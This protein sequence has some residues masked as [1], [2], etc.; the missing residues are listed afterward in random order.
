MQVLLELEDAGGEESGGRW[1]EA[2]AER[3]VPT[4]VR[5]HGVVA[6][7]PQEFWEEENQHGRASIYTT[8]IISNGSR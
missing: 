7:R 2:V 8:Q 1:R 3:T 5:A 4:S 6:Q